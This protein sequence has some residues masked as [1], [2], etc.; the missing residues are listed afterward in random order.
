ML[1]SSGSKEHPVS[2][3]GYQYFTSSMQ[4]VDVDCAISQ[5]L[6]SHWAF[7]HKASYHDYREQ[8]FFCAASM[9]KAKILY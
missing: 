4:Q 9:H 8:I 5:F 1:C 7:L 2:T 6:L 3:G